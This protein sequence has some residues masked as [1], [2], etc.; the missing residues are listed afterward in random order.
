MPSEI[1]GDCGN[2][3]F[4]PI[5]AVLSEETGKTVKGPRWCGTLSYHRP[6]PCANIE[7]VAVY[8]KEYTTDKLRW[9]DG[10]PTSGRLT[11]FSHS[12]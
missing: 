1:T 10:V 11:F 8:P 5:L 3:V 4:V 2:I 9:G 12:L 6:P 7:R